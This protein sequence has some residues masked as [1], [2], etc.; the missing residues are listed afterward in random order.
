MTIAGF[1]H[2]LEHGDPVNGVPR[3][4]LGSRVRGNDT[5]GFAGT[6]KT[7]GFSAGAVAD[8]IHRAP[9]RPGRLI[10]LD[11][12]PDQLI[13][14]RDCVTDMNENIDVV[15][16]PRLPAFAQTFRRQ[17]T[18]RHEVTSGAQ[19][20]RQV[21]ISNG[22]IIRVGWCWR[23]TSRRVDRR[24]RGLSTVLSEPLSDAD[25]LV[26]RLILL[27][28]QTLDARRQALLVTA[29]RADILTSM[30]LF[31]STPEADLRQADRAVMWFGSRLC[32]P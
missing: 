28:M 29:F 18:T 23:S 26:P 1:L 8:S 22:R 31:C 9:S 15:D 5:A 14:H 19:Q 3:W 12:L 27:V 24:K 21:F 6:G 4:I 32:E 2:T 16:R 25:H 13:Q 11:A 17:T 10:P 20:D 7:I 30:F